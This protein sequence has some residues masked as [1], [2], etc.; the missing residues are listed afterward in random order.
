[1][2]CV[3]TNKKKAEGYNAEN[4]LRHDKGKNT[5]EPGSEGTACARRFGKAELG[6]QVAASSCFGGCRK[7]VTVFYSLFCRG[8]VNPFGS[9]AGTND[10]KG[11]RKNNFTFCGWH[12]E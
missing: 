5:G 8:C 6:S 11:S 12:P 7:L 2:S 1:V 4:L 10:P 9:R 3:N